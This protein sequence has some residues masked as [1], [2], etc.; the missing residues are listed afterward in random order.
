MTVDQGGKSGVLVKFFGKY[1]SMPSGAVRLALK[2]NATVLPVFF[3]RINGPYIKL[4][5]NPPFKI[6]RTDDQVKDI[7]DNLGEL[8]HLFEGHI[9]KYPREYLW[10]YKIYKYTK[11]KNILILSDGKTGHLRQAEATANPRTSRS[12]VR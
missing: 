11:E 2:Y 7:T 5:I 3:R 6:K 4:I 12:F 1:A 9:L 10:S 8:I